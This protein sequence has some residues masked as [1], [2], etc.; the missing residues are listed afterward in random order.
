MTPDQGLPGAAPCRSGQGPE[1]QLQGKD[2]KSYKRRRR[3]PSPKGSDLQNGER[4]SVVGRRRLR[5]RERPNCHRSFPARL[6]PHTGLGVRY[7]YGEWPNYT[8][9]PI[10]GP[11]PKSPSSD[12]SHHRHPP[13]ASNRANPFFTPKSLKGV[14]QRRS[15]KCTIQCIR[16]GGSGHPRKRVH[17]G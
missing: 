4:V 2:C 6:L 13:F 9:C 14:I 7:S 15:R 16:M 8:R 10:K 1:S 12:S 3:E 11:A 17:C 5:S